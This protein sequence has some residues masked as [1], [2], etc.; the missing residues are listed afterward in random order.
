MINALRLADSDWD[1][2][3]AVFDLQ[4]VA[5]DTHWEDVSVTCAAN[6]Q[7]VLD[8]AAE[9]PSLQWLVLPSSVPVLVGERPSDP[10][11]VRLDGPFR[12][13][14]AVRDTTNI[15]GYLVGRVLTQHP[16]T[17]VFFPH[18]LKLQA[19]SIVAAFP[20]DVNKEAIVSRMVFL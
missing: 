3:N 13:Q 5:S 8:M 17:T 6:A 19:A 1:I 16:E 18:F 2:T 15:L 14:N 9:I 7:E 10:Q 11:L 4:C 12:D 20:A